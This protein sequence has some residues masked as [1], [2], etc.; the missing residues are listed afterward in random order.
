MTETGILLAS[1]PIALL[2]IAALI[3]VIGTCMR[4]DPQDTVNVSR[5]PQD[6]R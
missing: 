6:L 5:N 4:R 2:I 1:A 3:L